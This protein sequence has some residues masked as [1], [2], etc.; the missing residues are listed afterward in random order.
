MRRVA[1]NPRVTMILQTPS[2]KN[3]KM[4][5]PYFAAF[6]AARGIVQNTHAVVVLI[7]QYGTARFQEDGSGHVD[8]NEESTAPGT[9]TRFDCRTV[10]C[11]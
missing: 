8:W 6:P 7:G 11:I 9:T 3:E 5:I 1:K 10:V 4:R 2:G